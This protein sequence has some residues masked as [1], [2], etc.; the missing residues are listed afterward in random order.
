MYSTKTFYLLSFINRFIYHSHLSS[1][2]NN[3]HIK[4]LLQLCFLSPNFRT[5]TLFLVLFYPSGSGSGMFVSGQNRKMAPRIMPGKI[6]WCIRTSLAPFTPGWR[7][8]T[9]SRLKSASWILFGLSGLEPT[10]A[11]E[12]IKIF[13]ASQAPWFTFLCF[14][15]CSCGTQAVSCCKAFRFLHTQDFALWECPKWF[16]IAHDLR[17]IFFILTFL[18]WPFSSRE[19]PWIWPS[20]QDSFR[21][22][23]SKWATIK[24]QLHKKQ[25]NLIFWVFCYT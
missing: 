12:L 13:D 5:L 7:L 23:C 3:K 2:L 18:G 16:K 1:N 17:L 21:F 8:S 6:L 11:R 25:Q 15:I 24:N 19:Y 10:R 20:T 14:F 4:S 22:H 9:S